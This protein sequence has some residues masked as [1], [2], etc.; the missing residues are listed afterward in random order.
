[1]G[2]AQRVECC[3]LHFPLALRK[4]VSGDFQF[5]VV[6]VFDVQHG[7]YSIEFMRQSLL[8]S[9][10]DFRFL[11]VFGMRSFKSTPRS[12]A[13]SAMVARSWVMPVSRI[14]FMRSEMAARSVDISVVEVGDVG[15]FSYFRHGG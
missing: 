7:T 5:S 2:G 3:A 13:C 12:V 1:M 10:L 9:S 4:L 15:Q 14:S 8:S 11:R 6:Q